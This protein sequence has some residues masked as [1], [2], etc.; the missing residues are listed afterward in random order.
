MVWCI[1]ESD[2]SLRLALIRGNTVITK[3]YNCKELPLTTM[4][5]KKSNK[6]VSNN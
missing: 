6:K 3:A 1:L 5:T 4:E 2:T